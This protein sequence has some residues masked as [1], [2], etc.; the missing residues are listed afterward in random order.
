MNKDVLYG[1]PLNATSHVVTSYQVE[2]RLKWHGVIHFKLQVISQ[3]VKVHI[4]QN[5]TASAEMFDSVVVF[6]FVNG[7]LLQV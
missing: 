7:N 5:P 1:I 3:S 2:I 6:L 4:E